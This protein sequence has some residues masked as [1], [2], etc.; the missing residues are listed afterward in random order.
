MEISKE[1]IKMLT[2]LSSLKYNIKFKKG[3]NKKRILLIDNG[4]IQKGITSQGIMYII[5]NIVKKDFK[6]GKNY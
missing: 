1:R 2:M 3:G 6:N 5:P 4:R